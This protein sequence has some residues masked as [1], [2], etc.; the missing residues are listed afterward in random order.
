[1]ASLSLLGSDAAGLLHGR[2]VASTCNGVYGSIVEV[3]T[4]GDHPVYVGRIIRQQAL[5]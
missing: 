2:G 5:G 1:M 3:G 4:C